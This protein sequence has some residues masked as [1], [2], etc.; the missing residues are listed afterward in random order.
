MQ[1]DEDAL[2][3]VG[4]NCE[5]ISLADS[6]AISSVRTEPSV[7]PPR[8][9]YSERQRVRDHE[10]ACAYGRWLKSLSP[11]ERAQVDALGLGKSSLSYRGRLSDVDLDVER[12]G[13]LASP[14]H[15]DS[16]T[17]ALA[18]ALTEFCHWLVMPP[19]QRGLNAKAIGQRV[20]M[21]M[22]VMRPD[23]IGNLATTEIGALVDAR[24][25]VLSRQARAFSDR[26]G[27]RGRA[28][29]RDS[30][31]AAQSGAAK[32]RHA[33]ETLEKGEVNGLN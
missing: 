22:W 1:H 3:S 31:R 21:A 15:S 32:Q 11:E 26:F 30:S 18:E 24:P 25:E 20:I 8:F 28:Q 17:L 7:R 13:T 12:M 19:G 29:F 33:R 5:A 27:V 23:I 10:Y 16:F 9:I 14:E 6:S 4:D 2:P